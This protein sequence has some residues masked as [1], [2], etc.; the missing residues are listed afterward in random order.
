MDA[1]P[2]IPPNPFHLL[3]REFNAAVALGAAVCISV[4]TS[5]K[6]GIV[7]TGHMFVVAAA[8]MEAK[9]ESCPRNTAAWVSPVQRLDVCVPDRAGLE[10][11]KPL[12]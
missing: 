2:P 12:M 3:T 4:T 6:R 7:C 1:L 5:E 8:V 9:G 10:P 11:V